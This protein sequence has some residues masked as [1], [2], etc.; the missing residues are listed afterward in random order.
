MD[1]RA[2]TLIVGKLML[3]TYSFFFLSL[4]LDP[5]LTTLMF[6][7]HMFDDHE[8]CLDREKVSL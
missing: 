8:L 2:T 3:K 7:V 6:C 5:L 4:L 1:G